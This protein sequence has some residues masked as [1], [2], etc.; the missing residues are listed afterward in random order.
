MKILFVKDR[1]PTA[2]AG[3]VVDVK[4]GFGRNFLLPHGIA[5]LATEKA[6]LQAE[7]LR[8]DAQKRRAILRSEWVDLAERIASEQATIRSLCS[9]T[10]RLYGAITATAV[11]EVVSNMIG[12]PINRK[13][14]RIGQPIRTI[15]T[16]SVKVILFSEVEANLKLIVEPEE[17]KS[18]ASSESDEPRATDSKEEPTATT[19]TAE[20]Q[21]TTTSETNE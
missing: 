19:A 6:L 2:M 15:G 8:A 20:E 10:G 3:D 16:H 13:N 14:I 4:N 11:A 21:P 18:D 7:A 12:R 17:K 1:L 5:V 9:E